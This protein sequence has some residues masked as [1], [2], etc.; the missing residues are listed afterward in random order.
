MVVKDYKADGSLPQRLLHCLSER[1]V[2]VS[3]WDRGDEMR[4]QKCC[5]PTVISVADRLVLFKGVTL[6]KDYTL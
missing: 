4:V 5:S 2:A 3:E 6:T 1:E